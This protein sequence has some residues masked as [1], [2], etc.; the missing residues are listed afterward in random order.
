MN[1]LK[2]IN[3]NGR[4][5]VDSRDVAEMIGKEHKHLLRDIRGY[6][7]IMGKSNFGPAEFFIES[8]YT[9]S[10]GKPRPHF[11]LTKKGCDMVANKLTGEKGVLFTAEYVTRFEEME[12]E[13]QEINKPSYMID[14]PIKR[15]EKWI[16]EQKEKQRLEAKTKMLEK[17]RELDMPYTQFGKVVAGSNASI[18]VGS[19]AKMMYE[20]HGINLGRNKMFAWLRNKGFL[21]KS[22]RERNN[23]KQIY[24]EQGLFEVKPTIISRTEGDVESLTTLITGKG[25]V[26]LAELL[27][28]EYK[29]RKVV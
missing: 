28:N 25:Q 24:I 22:G 15:A 23:P 21:I 20:K 2:V 16:A 14:D 9:D 13:L 29:T 10:Q 17:Q 7:G 11:Y 26:K 5:V 19:F 3:Q 18:N 4:F 27:I 8:Y 12:R 1:Q 6:I